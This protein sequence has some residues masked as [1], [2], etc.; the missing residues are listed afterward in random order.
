MFTGFYTTDKG[1][2]YIARAL[3][4]KSLVLTKSQYGNGELPEGAV[5]TSMTQLVAPL[6]D[7]QISKKNALGNSMTTTTQ[8]SNRV[9]GIILDPFYFMEAGIFGKVMNEDGTADEDAPET[10]LFY[11]NALT[12]EKADYIPGT[13]TEFLINWPIAISESA[14]VTVEINESLVYLTLEDLNKRVP[15][16]IA[17]ATEAEAIA[18]TDN[19]KMMTPAKVASYVDKVLGDINTILDEINGEEI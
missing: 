13:L 16:D 10:L 12:K 1:H 19:T 3:A 6:A 5:I 8:F 9:N 7:M 2:N 14:N 17:I 4:G 15:F 11:A 18:G